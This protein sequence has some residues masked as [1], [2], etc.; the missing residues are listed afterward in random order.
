[1]LRLKIIQFLI[2]KFFNRYHPK[3]D[4]VYTD[5]STEKENK[6]PI[7]LVGLSMKSGE[8]SKWLSVVG[9]V[10]DSRG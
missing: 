4:I 10:A 7:L 1:L 8:A 2:K 3:R 6:C 5:F 9:V